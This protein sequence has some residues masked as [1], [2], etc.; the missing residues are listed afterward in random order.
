MLVCH[1]VSWNIR[2]ECCLGLKSTLPL[3]QLGCLFNQRVS[4]MQAER[5]GGG[6][7][8]DYTFFVRLPFLIGSDSLFLRFCHHRSLMV[9]EASLRMCMQFMTV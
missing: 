1:D 3:F 5:D 6:R 8:R 2:D 7:C 9:H 4:W